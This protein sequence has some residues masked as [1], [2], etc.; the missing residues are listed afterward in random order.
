MGAGISTVLLLGTLALVGADEHRPSHRPLL[1]LAVV[2][3][4]GGV[5]IYGM[6][7]MPPFGSPDNPAHHHVA[8]R[9]VQESGRR[10]RHTQR[11]HL[12]ADLLPS[13]RHDGGDHRDLHGRDRRDAADRHGT[14]P[15][16]GRQRSGKRPKL[17]RRERHLP[18]Q[19]APRPGSHEQGSPGGS[20]DPASQCED[21]DP[22]HPPLR[23]LRPV[24][25]RLR[26]RRRIPG[27]R[28]PRLGL[29]PIRLDLR[30]TPGHRSPSR[31]RRPCLL[32]ARGDH[33]RRHGPC[34]HAARGELSSTTTCSRPTPTMAS[35]WASSR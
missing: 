17:G 14:A 31:E 20:R 26:P 23:S 22:L 34:R 10:D 35:T 29:H 11:R 3:I 9:Y 24:P 30:V 13:V 2:L 19:F 27:G 18:P 33:L 32:S 15:L 8:P 6:S 4:T 7:D 28:N 25:R 1:P 16:S 12:G 21:A 5:L